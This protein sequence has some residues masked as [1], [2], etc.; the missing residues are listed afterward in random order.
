MWF[1]IRT[2]LARGRGGYV[3]LY[4]LL[5]CYHLLQHRHGVLSKQDRHGVFNKMTI[6]AA[7]L[8]LF[9]LLNHL[10]VQTYIYFFCTRHRDKSELCY[11][12]SQQAALFWF[13]RQYDGNTMGQ[14]M[15]INCFLLYQF[16]RTMVFEYLEKKDKIIIVFFL[17]NI[18]SE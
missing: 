16:P 10:P 17:S 5:L 6:E 7:N 14:Q 1:C 11:D 3:I 13:I 12:M 4:N 8:I 15:F 2:Y 18:A 9:R